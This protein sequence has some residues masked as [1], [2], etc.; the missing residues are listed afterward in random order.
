MWGEGS[1]TPIALTFTTTE[2]LKTLDASKNAAARMA[3]SYKDYQEAE[4]TRT[5][6]DLSKCIQGRAKGFAP[7]EPQTAEFFLTEMNSNMSINT[8]ELVPYDPAAEVLLPGTTAPIKGNDITLDAM[9]T[10]MIE[11]GGVYVD[12]VIDQG[13]TAAVHAARSAVWTISKVVYDAGFGRNVI[14]R[15]E[16]Q[17]FQGLSNGGSLRLN[18]VTMTTYITKNALTEGDV[19]DHLKQLLAKAGDVITGTV[20]VR[21][22]QSGFTVKAYKMVGDAGQDVRHTGAGKRLA[23]RRVQEG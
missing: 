5:I 6:S 22:S 12:G 13:L 7:G 18:S 21:D 20:T 16:N 4:H 14:T 10:Q 2:A 11:S 23:R 19:K 3:V 9:V 1:V 17:T 8:V 15:E